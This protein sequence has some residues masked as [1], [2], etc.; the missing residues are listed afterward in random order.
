[1][2]VYVI[3]TRRIGDN[4]IFNS[5]NRFEIE[6]TKRANA[7]DFRDLNYNTEYSESHKYYYKFN[8]DNCAVIGYAHLPGENNRDRVDMWKDWL[9]TLCHGDEY[10]FILHDKDYTNIDT[11]F[12]FQEFNGDQDTYIF[13]HRRDDFFY[14]LL[15][16]IEKKGNVSASD[17]D[18][19]FQKLVELTNIRNEMERCRI[20][21]INPNRD[22]FSR[23]DKLLN[24]NNK[25]VNQYDEM[26]ENNVRNL[27][28][29]T[30]NGIMEIISECRY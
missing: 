17:F 8:N 12:Q 21:D 28:I 24:S 7:N 30:R 13:F 4:Y 14:K 6:E 25:Y 18:N 29:E 5:S 11:P 2:K 27:L 22:I 15:K 26:I 19:R 23:I 10:T 16:D 9:K 20:N 3:T 1:M